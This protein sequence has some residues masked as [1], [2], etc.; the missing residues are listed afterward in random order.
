MYLIPTTETL[1]KYLQHYLD[2]LFRFPRF[3]PKICIKRA[4]VTITNFL[5]LLQAKQRASVKWLLSKAYNNRVPENLR[6]PYY[7]DHEVRV[8]KQ[9]L[10]IFIKQ[11]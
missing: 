6:E 8:P 11:C 4:I 7:V 3:S 2:A 1:Q 5:S 10:A 9:N